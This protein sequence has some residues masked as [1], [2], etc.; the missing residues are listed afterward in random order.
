M[1]ALNFG[2]VDSNDF[3]ILCKKFVSN[4]EGFLK[5]A[6]S[7]IEAGFNKLSIGVN[8]LIDQ[9]SIILQKYKS[10]SIKQ[11]IEQIKKS[12]LEVVGDVTV[13]SD[14]EDESKLSSENLTDTIE[15]LATDA[16]NLVYNKQL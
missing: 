10:D 15:Q 11:K 9:I 12:I 4:P 6:I 7:G 8:E 13:T 2:S 14:S 1:S 16:V 5:K 3:K